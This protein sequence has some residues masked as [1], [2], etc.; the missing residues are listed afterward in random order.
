[1]QSEIKNAAEKNDITK[2]N[3]LAD[4][5]Q[6]RVLLEKEVINIKKLFHLVD[7]LQSCASWMLSK[8]MPY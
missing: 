3:V 2:L 1:M 8:I 4:A 6:K 7:D 5:V